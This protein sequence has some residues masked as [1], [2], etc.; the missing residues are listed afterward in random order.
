MHE[1]FTDII[2]NIDQ[3]FEHAAVVLE[4]FPTQTVHSDLEA[5]GEMKT[6]ESSFAEEMDRKI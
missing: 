5:R 1:P 6:G 2:D 4:Y 3:G